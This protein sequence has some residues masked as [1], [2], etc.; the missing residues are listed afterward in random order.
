MG[1]N[2]CVVHSTPPPPTPTLKQLPSPLRVQPSLV[3]PKDQLLKL[4]YKC[5]AKTTQS[6]CYNWCMAP[7]NYS[8]NHTQKLVGGGVPSA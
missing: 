4:K 2:C 6:D 7:C 1:V 8:Y 3:R 5:L